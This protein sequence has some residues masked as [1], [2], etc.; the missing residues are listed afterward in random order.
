MSH[1]WLSLSQVLWSLIFGHRSEGN[2]SLADSTDAILS[3]LDLLQWRRDARV[4]AAEFT[5]L[6]AEWTKMGS[7]SVSIARFRQLLHER[8]YQETH[9]DIFV[10]LL[11]HESRIH[12]MQST[13]LNN[14]WM[15]M[16]EEIFFTLDPQGHGRW[17]WDQVYFFAA[18]LI[19]LDIK[20]EI[21]EAGH[22]LQSSVPSHTMNGNRSSSSSHGNDVENTNLSPVIMTAVASQL[23]RDI[24]GQSIALHTTMGSTVIP[25]DRK[26][27]RD[28]CIIT[29]PQLQRYFLARE[30][31]YA[32][33]SALSTHIQRC[34][35]VLAH[36]LQGGGRSGTSAEEG[37][38][39]FK[40]LLRACLLSDTPI[41]TDGSGLGSG[42]RASASASTG[43][44]NGKG[45]AV[46]L[47]CLW[48]KGVLSAAAAAGGGEGAGGGDDVLAQTQQHHRRYGGSG[49]QGRRQER[50]G[51]QEPY[52]AIV[53]YLLTEFEACLSVVLLA[54][55]YDLPTRPSNPTP[56]PLST[57][58][59]PEKNKIE[60]NRDHA[61]P[62]PSG[63]SSS[64]NRWLVDEEVRQVVG[65][66]CHG[67]QSWDNMNELG[68]TSL[69][70]MTST[71][72]ASITSNSDGREGVVRVGISTQR[73]DP[74]M[75]HKLQQLN[76]R[77]TL[78]QQRASP[79]YLVILAAMMNYKRMQ[80]HLSF[81][82]L[83]MR[84]YIL[85]TSSH[86]RHAVDACKALLPTAK[87]THTVAQSIEKVLCQQHTVLVGQILYTPF[88]HPLTHPLVTL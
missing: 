35:D 32:K 45:W 27:N 78:Q 62:N 66:L 59:S 20:S 88:S 69:P 23:I 51:E 37:K 84:K 30:L 34:I 11:L 74:N 40:E 21:H 61:S 73:I 12:I 17:G 7:S 4:T 26:N 9:L 36:V 68:K 52:P 1:R 22:A 10:A 87:N 42:D 80:Q 53:L 81:A 18:C 49:D 76:D 72:T 25:S 13:T 29:V 47:P 67:Y 77:I 8:R 46:G 6:Y 63:V 86:D 14:A 71:Q 15:T 28:V 65:N 33:L 48:H 56:L 55:P 54:Y 57:S 38:G 16:T 83:E 44:S 85:H 2:S 82:L 43:E 79:E 60:N 3:F 19:V 5:T 24:T 58:S 31:S 50:E 64:S 70:T 41:A 75:A 39:A